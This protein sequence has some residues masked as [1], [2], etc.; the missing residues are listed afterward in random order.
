MSREQWG[1]GYHNGKKDSQTGTM[2]GLWLHTKFPNGRIKNQGEIIRQ[3]SNGKCVVQLYSFLSGCPTVCK[4]LSEDEIESCAL[5]SSASDMR[6]AYDVEMRE[7]E[8]ID[9]IS[10]IKWG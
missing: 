9:R 1:H 8:R 2:V 5:Y 10:D 6:D 3:L 7:L 4:C